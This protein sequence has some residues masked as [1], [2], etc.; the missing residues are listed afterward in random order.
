MLDSEEC[1]LQ[2]NKCIGL[3]NATPNLHLKALHRSL[4]QCW[5][6]FSDEKDRQSSLPERSIGQQPS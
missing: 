3:A 6:I 2:A 1:R 5:R 4:A